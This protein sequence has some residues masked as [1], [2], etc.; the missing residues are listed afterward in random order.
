[1]RNVGKTNLKPNYEKFAKASIRELFK[2]FNITTTG[3]KQTQVQKMRNRFGPNKLTDNAKK[4]II[5]TILGAYIT[6]FTIVLIC[7][8]LVSFITDVVL[9]PPGE[10]NYLG[11]GII[12]GMVIISGTMTL[13]QSLRS[14]KAVEQLKT[15]IKSV[16]TVKRASGIQKI[17]VDHVVC[18]DIVQLSVGDMVPADMRLIKSKDLLVSEAS[19][20]GESY[21]VEKNHL[22]SKKNVKSETDYENLVF[23]GS[24]VTNGQAEGVVIATG[25][26]TLFG[27][28]AHSA[29]ITPTETNF[30]LGIRKTSYLF[31][32]FTVIMTTVI[33]LINGLTKGDWLEALPF[34]LSVAVG[35]TPEM[36]PMIV[37]TNLVKGA[38]KMAKGGTI[39]KNL[40]AIQNLGAIDV[41]CT[42]KTGTLTQNQFSLNHYL[43]W[44][45]TT[46]E[47]TLKWAYLN[48]RY[49]TGFNNPLDQAVIDAAKPE[50]KAQ[51]ANYQKVDEIPFDFERRRMTVI[52]K[53][54]SQR[55]YELIT[56]GAVEEMLE[57]TNT[58]YSTGSLVP[59]TIE[60]KHEILRQVSQ[61]N[62]AGL[63]VVAVAH[64][65]LAT[66]P[67]TCSVKD[68]TNLSF[69]GILSFLDS[70]KPT[71]KQALSALK[72]KGITIK[73]LT[74][75]NAI[76]TKSIC[77]QVGLRVTGIVSGENIDHLTD[78]EL[79]PVVTQ[80]NVFIKLTP[81]NKRRII[82]ALRKNKHTVGFLGDGINDVP[83]IKAADVGISVNSAVDVVKESADV[84]LTA[85]DLVILKHGILIG[86]EVFGNIMKYIKATASSNFGN[87]FS[88]LIASIF[89][90]F[91]PMLPLQILLLNFIY[92]LSCMSIPWDTMDKDYLER[93]KK[94]R[95]NSIG[96][97][98]V[99]FGPTSSIFDITTYLLMFFVICPAIAG[100][101]FI[102]LTH[103]NQMYF[104]ALFQSGWFIESLWSQTMVL[105]AL[106]TAKIPFIQSSASA[107]LTI[108]T[109]LSIVIGTVI[110]F[111]PIGKSLGLTAVPDSYWIWLVITIFS[112]LALATVVKSTYIRRYKG[113]I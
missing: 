19:L 40:K 100:G 73:V 102:H 56:K 78:Q 68:E 81:Q 92:D 55:H 23:M 84:I 51:A 76:V 41:L 63:R 94:W 77:Q 1:M 57:I 70:P 105:H 12:F 13:I 101:D 7:I 58:V 4:L 3:L 79:G 83:A 44:K 32:K 39:I 16:T 15:M 29:S 42:D 75:D 65:R 2:D 91:L 96:K 95:V 24:Y 62:Q 82:K 52:L 74:G 53:D 85:S 60:I 8:G 99:W 61:L 47:E 37:T 9:A 64:K 86:R 50:V 45:G 109:S 97:F 36:L 28:I 106:R 107:V 46:D 80:N 21:P 98:M 69:I 67:N 59:L 33:F 22:Q 113:F 26:Q 112:Y 66:T 71:A 54:Q 6:P 34:G 14:T 10:R 72:S 104:I 20:T 25:N 87:M 43:N 90:P 5:R 38:T 17:P 30:D 31:I 18:G 48:S 111:T 88:V 108:T 103:P 93:P 110:P 11:S 35:L 49:Q 89:L 27:G